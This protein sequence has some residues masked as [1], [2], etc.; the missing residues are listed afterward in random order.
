MHS[1]NF[2]IA[3]FYCPLVTILKKDFNEYFYNTL[4]KKDDCPIYPKRK[5]SEGEMFRKL[6]S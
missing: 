5:D 3:I 1:K 2:L 6:K 4:K